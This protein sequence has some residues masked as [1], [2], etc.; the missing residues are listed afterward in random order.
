MKKI[1]TGCRK[2]I[3]KTMKTSKSISSRSGH[4]EAG[5][6]SG[7][8]MLLKKFNATE[9]ENRRLSLE[10]QKETEVFS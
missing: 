5:A 8:Q 7:Y 2:K 3:L 4:R 9:K 10:L 1:K 6:Q